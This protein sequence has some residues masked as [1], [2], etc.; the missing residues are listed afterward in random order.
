[1]PVVEEPLWLID[2]APSVEDLAEAVAHKLKQQ[3]KKTA[4]G[5]LLPWPARAAPPLEEN[6]LADLVVSSNAFDFIGA[7]A[8][9]QVVA[10]TNLKKL[11]VAELRRRAQGVVSELRQWDT[12]WLADANA[13][14]YADSLEQ[15][16]WQLL[17]G[18]TANSDEDRKL[19]YARCVDLGAKALSRFKEAGAGSSY[20]DTG[21]DV[22]DKMASAGLDATQRAAAAIVKL[23]GKALETATGVPSWVFWGGG[24]LVFL[25]L[26]FGAWKVLMAAA[27]AAGRVAARR[28]LP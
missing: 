1:V 16:E 11:P 2:D 26:G 3:Q 18:D 14:G 6:D 20:L 21:S 5:R 8:S 9:P 12:S 15:A 24:I 28:Y 17:N 23:P 27:P 10:F 25:T 13:K 19:A 4:V 7:E 22:A